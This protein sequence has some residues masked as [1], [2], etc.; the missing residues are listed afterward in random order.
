MEN[1]QIN[2]FLTINKAD[3]NL[4]KINIFIGPQA[5]GKSVIAK[6]IKYFKDY[7]TEILKLASEGKTKRDIIKGQKVK[8]FK[9]FPQQYWENDAFEIIYSNK[10]Y[11]VCIQNKDKSSFKITISDEL[12]KTINKLRQITK[13]D[14]DYLIGESVNGS[15]IKRKKIDIDTE[16][17]STLSNELFSAKN[18]KIESVLYI[19]AGRSFFANLQKNVF[20]FL[21]SNIDIDY[22]LTEFGSIYEQTKS[23]TSQKIFTVIGKEVPSQ[24]NKLVEEL[25]CGKYSS[26]KGEDWITQHNK[27]ININNS[28]S[29]QQESLPMA[30]MLST[31]P[32]IKTGFG[33]S[34]IIEEP[35]AH[36]FPSAQ[37]V[38]VSLI[39]NAYNRAESYC[40]YTITTHSPYILSAMNNLIQAGNTLA[41]INSQ[42]NNNDQKNNLF[43]IVPESQLIDFNDVT[44]YMVNNGKVIG[45]LDS[46]LK[47]LD[48]NEIDRISSIF[49]D[50]FDKLI[51]ME[52]SVSEDS[53][54]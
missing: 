53:G 41:A 14:M 38:V 54:E 48:S 8:F 15:I 5:Q 3:I 6:L 13:K 12:T 29:G 2:N 36:L 22:F 26:E 21:S 39:A 20:S 24:V 16:L 27:K 23:L 42:N 7:P 37:S 52:F 44:A 30:L 45:I 18:T 19:P 50:N 10:H 4:K 46:E 32:Y 11:S 1:I 35:E 25:I 9:I 33:R 34:F 51:E 17:R 28:S 43:K 40:S 31:W 47:I 49:S